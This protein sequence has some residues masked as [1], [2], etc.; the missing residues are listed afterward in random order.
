MLTFEEELGDERSQELSEVVA[1]F[2]RELVEKYPNLTLEE[3]Y[4]KHLNFV[5][6]SDGLSIDKWLPAQLKKDS[7]FSFYSNDLIEEIWAKPD[8]VW[9]SDSLLFRQYRGNRNPVGRKIRDRITNYDSLLY[10]ERNT[11]TFNSQGKYLKAI[12]RIANSNEIAEWYYELKS[13]AGSVSPTISA[14]AFLNSRV[15]VDDYLVKR[16]ILIETYTRTCSS[17]HNSDA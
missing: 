11:E 12:Q 14:K 5:L 6:K 13:N 3:A 7:V 9:I 17:K 2:D 16:I 1:H 10:Y 15:D 8:S 4:E